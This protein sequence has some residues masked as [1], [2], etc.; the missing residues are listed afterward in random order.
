MD[1]GCFLVTAIAA[2]GWS[3]INT[4]RAAEAA[5][6]KA[7]FKSQCSI[8]HSA[9]QGRN[10]VGPSLFGVVGRRTGQAPGFYYSAANKN[11]GL[12]WDI[13]R[14]PQN[15]E[16]S[17]AMIRKPSDTLSQYTRQFRGTSSRKNVK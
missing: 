9:Q 10:Q 1:K 5:A 17:G 2:C 7:V 14:S 12:A 3:A 16:L 15:P 11:S 6:G 8:C 13:P 4:V